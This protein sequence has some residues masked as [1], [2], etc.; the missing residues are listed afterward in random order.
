MALNS[1][2]PFRHLDK[3]TPGPLSRMRSFVSLPSFKT[4]NAPRAPHGTS[5]VG[6]SGHSMVTGTPSWRWEREAFRVRDKSQRAA[7]EECRGPGQTGRLGQA[8]L[9][10]RSHSATL[11]TGDEQDRRVMRIRSDQ[12]LYHGLLG[13][14]TEHRAK[15]RPEA[16]SLCRGLGRAGR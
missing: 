8:L 3:Q 15:S 5:D 6:T 9:I 7:S 13:I 1:R 4:K 16:P 12:T 14:K 11:Y 10:T 2:W